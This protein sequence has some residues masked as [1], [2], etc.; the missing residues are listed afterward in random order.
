MISSFLIV[1]EQIVI[2]FALMAIGF[3]CG[4]LKIIN[5]SIS[6]GLSSI[7]VN[8]TIPATILMSFHRAFD[9]VLLKD[10]LFS[11]AIGAVMY[12]VCI[13]LSILTIREKSDKRRNVIRSAVIFCNCAMM[14]MPLESA[15]L[16]ADGVFFG[17]AHAG[18]FNL[19][20]WTYALYIISGSSGK[21]DL[22]KAL[23]N[24]CILCTF[25][26]MILFLFNI[27][28]PKI[29]YTIIGKVSDM[30]LPLSMMIIGYTISSTNIGDVLSDK[31]CWLAALERLVIVPMILLGLLLLIGKSGTAAITAVLTAASP[32]AASIN[33]LAVI[34]GKDEKLAA[35]LVSISTILSLL[36]L[37]VVAAVAQTLLA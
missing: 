30:N 35:G 34:Y 6:K 13:P 4:K 8:L 32:A 23:L 16:G 14:A 28:L 24:P 17:A 33:I 29:T 5:S 26:G 25:A 27:S 9:A 37:P 1:G 12:A 31:W 19:I 22:K 11:A 7:A 3:I 15:L 21:V 10:F 20:F 36:T 2:V 18:L